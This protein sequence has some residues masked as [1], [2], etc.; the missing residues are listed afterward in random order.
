MQDITVD[1]FDKVVTNIIA[2]HFLGFNDDELPNG[3]A[4]HNKTLQE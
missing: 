4:S 2:N 3:G 1:Q